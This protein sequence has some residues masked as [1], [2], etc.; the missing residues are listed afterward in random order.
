MQGWIKDI[1][2]TKYAKGS[3]VDYPIV[4]DPKRELAVKFGM[5]CPHNPP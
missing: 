1:E 2:S 5:V 4:C 3:K